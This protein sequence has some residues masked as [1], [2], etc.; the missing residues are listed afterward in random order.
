[1][2]KVHM[3]SLAVRRRFDAD[4]GD[5]LALDVAD[6]DLRDLRGAYKFERRMGSNRRIARLVAIATVVPAWKAAS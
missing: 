5:W 1:M 3:A 4:S 6:S 2:A